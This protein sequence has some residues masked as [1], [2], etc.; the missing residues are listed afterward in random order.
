MSGFGEARWIA[1]E[2]LNVEHLLDVFTSIDRSMGVVWDTCCHFIQHLVWH[3]PRQTVLRS[4][5]EGLPDDHRSKP[6][7]LLMLSLLF[8]QIGND[9]EREKLLTHTLELQR[10]R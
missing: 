3:K 5:I 10:Q 8:Q 1:L 6:R 4:K 9:G 7:C 2:D